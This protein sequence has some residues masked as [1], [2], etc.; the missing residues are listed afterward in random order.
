[1]L[2]GA[3]SGREKKRGEKR[4]EKNRLSGVKIEA[5]LEVQRDA[6]KVRSFASKPLFAVV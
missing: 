6:S 4:K 3:K 1:L 5:A 2:P